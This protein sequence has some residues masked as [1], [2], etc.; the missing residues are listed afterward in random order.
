MHWWILLSDSHISDLARY[1][2][3]S[4]QAVACLCLDTSSKLPQCVCV[5]WVYSV[6][7]IVFSCM[8]AY[9]DGYVCWLWFVINN[10]L[11][12]W[13]VCF[14]SDLRR[15]ASVVVGL[16][17]FIMWWRYGLQLARLVG[18]GRPSFWVIGRKKEMNKKEEE[19][20]HNNETHAN[21]IPKPF[22]LSPK[23]G[24]LHAN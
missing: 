13:F 9:A 11:K 1:V 5:E 7:I 16:V 12:L 4:L 14:N 3:L 22:W 19:E 6:P 24:I 15:L 23:A 10:G 18:G 17:M 21:F 8:L 20:K 2:S